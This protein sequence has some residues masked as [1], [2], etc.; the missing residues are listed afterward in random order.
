MRRGRTPGLPRTC[1]SLVVPRRV[2]S[3]LTRGSPFPNLAAADPSRRPRASLRQP[4]NPDPRYFNSPRA[5]P[6][7]IR[8]FPAFNSKAGSSSSLAPSPQEGWPWATGER[9]C[10]RSGRSQRAR[11]SVLPH[12]WFRSPVSEAA[13]RA[14]GP[15]PRK[16]ECAGEQPVGAGFVAPRPA[17]RW[18]HAPPRPAPPGPG[19]GS[20][21]GSGGRGGAERSGRRIVGRAG[22]LAG[23]PARDRRRAAAEAQVSASDRGRGLTVEARVGGLQCRDGAEGEWGCVKAGVEWGA[24]TS[25]GV[26]EGLP[27]T[28]RELDE[29]E[30]S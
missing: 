15:A 27:E 12:T 28:A 30:E 23:D 13:D 25:L 4:Q 5:A 29:T 14:P 11:L 9:K 17:A 3:G 21:Q 8:H 18:R 10:R 6:R 22:G 1:A 20:A 19:S 24:G 7:G 16:R 2:R 26:V